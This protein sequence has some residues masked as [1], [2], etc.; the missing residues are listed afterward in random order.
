MKEEASFKQPSTPERASE[1]QQQKQ[2]CGEKKPTSTSTTTT[3]SSSSHGDGTGAT[4]RRRIKKELP[5]GPLVMLTPL[6][7]DSDISTPGSCFVSSQNIKVRSY[8]IHTSWSTGTYS[9]SG[10][11]AIILCFTN[12]VLT[13]CIK[14]H[15]ASPR[16]QISLLDLVN[17]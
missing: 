8:K 10:E 12:K 13:C 11:G 16:V 5:D 2:L 14:I 9:E 1:Q 17:C 7:S 6:L 15:Y 4:T 3:I